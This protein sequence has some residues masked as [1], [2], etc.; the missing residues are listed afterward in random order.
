MK[1]NSKIGGVAQK[2]VSTAFFLVTFICLLYFYIKVKYLPFFL[3]A[4]IIVMPVVVNAFLHLF[5]CK[6]PSKR[7]TKKTF[8]EGTKKIK[9]FFSKIWYAVKLCAYGI[10]VA[11]IK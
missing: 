3:A 4:A 10:S 8:E 6:M 5:A 7:P 2:I 11:Y 1:H 9:K